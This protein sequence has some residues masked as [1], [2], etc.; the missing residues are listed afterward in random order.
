MQ[1]DGAV[2]V[3]STIPRHRRLNAPLAI[4]VIAAAMVALQVW[5]IP[6]VTSGVGAEDAD[7][8]AAGAGSAVYYPLPH[9][10]A[11]GVYY[12]LPYGKAANSDAADNVN[13]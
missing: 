4:L 1:V 9:G 5:A 3:V 11:D 7:S 6:L 10:K 8:E 2:Q 12:P 13:R